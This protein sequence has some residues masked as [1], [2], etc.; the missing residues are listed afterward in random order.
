VLMLWTGSIGSLETIG[1]PM[2]GNAWQRVL[3]PAD[4]LRPPAARE[5]NASREGCQAR[6]PPGLLWFFYGICT[7][8]VVCIRARNMHTMH[9]T[10]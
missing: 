2:D 9:T 1:P 4:G 5:G 10:Y 8:S 3:L 6:Q 7:T